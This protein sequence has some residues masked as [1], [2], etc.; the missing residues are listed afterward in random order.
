MELLS[1]LLFKGKYLTKK[2]KLCILNV[3][4]YLLL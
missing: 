3:C 4:N 2:Y 1:L